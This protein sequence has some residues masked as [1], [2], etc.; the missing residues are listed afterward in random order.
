MST[1]KVTPLNIIDKTPRSCTYQ[2]KGI[3]GAH[4]KDGYLYIYLS[5]YLQLF[6]GPWP[7][8]HILDPIHNR[9]DSLDGRSA[10]SQGCYLQTEQLKHRINADIHASSGIQTHSPRVRAGED[11]SLP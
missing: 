8:F 9:H 6:V 10:P 1:E 7:L 3:L 11:G 5:I 4:F 2:R